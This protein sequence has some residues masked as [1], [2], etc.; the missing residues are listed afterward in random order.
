MGILMEYTPILPIGT[1]VPQGSILGPLLFIIYRKYIQ[2]SNV[3]L[4]VDD[5]NLINPLF[6]QHVLADQ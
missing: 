4:Y 1:G 2:N 6:I 3:I 5:T